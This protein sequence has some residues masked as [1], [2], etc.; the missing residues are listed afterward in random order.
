MKDIYSFITRSVFFIEHSSIYVTHICGYI[1]LFDEHKTQQLFKFFNVN[2]ARE[3]FKVVADSCTDPRMPN[4]F[5][6]NIDDLWKFIKITP[7]LIDIGFYNFNKMQLG[8]RQYLLSRIREVTER[9]KKDSE[10]SNLI[11]ERKR[12]SSSIYD[13]C[14]SIDKYGQPE[15]ITLFM[16]KK[17]LFFVESTYYSD[18]IWC[19]IVGLTRKS[20]TKVTKLFD[21]ENAQNIFTIIESRFYKPGRESK[22]WL[23]FMDYCRQ[24]DV[25]YDRTSARYWYNKE[26]LP[27]TKFLLREFDNSHTVHSEW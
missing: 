16:Y 18:H 13:V 14:K 11:S 5:G 20:T 1:D 25:D 6:E 26:N 12:G 9:R 19:D 3:L 23:D 2:T 8:Y 17:C 7:D 27:L 24:S 4:R 10:L 22:I 15:K 21:A